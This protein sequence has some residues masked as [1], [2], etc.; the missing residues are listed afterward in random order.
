MRR[1]RLVGETWLNAGPDDCVLHK[2]EELPPELIDSVDNL[3][4]GDRVENALDRD[5]KGRL[6]GKKRNRIPNEVRN[7]VHSIRK[8]GLTGTEIGDLLGIT[9]KSV[10]NILYREPDTNTYYE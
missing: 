2:N 6:V 9:E 3:W 1:H 8:L 5:K 4:L 10:F 7:R